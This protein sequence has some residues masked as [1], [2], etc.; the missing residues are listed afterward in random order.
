MWVTKI[1]AKAA[2]EA[3]R[4]RI[5]EDARQKG[6]SPEAI[7]SMAEELDSPCTEEMAAFDK[8]IYYA[9]QD[10]WDVIVFDTAPTGH[11]LRLLELPV[12]WSKQL[13]V[14]IYVSVEST[15]ADDVAKRRFGKVIDMMRD[16]DRCTFAFVMYPE[17]TPIVESY[18][19]M[20]ELR[21]VG[22]EP[23]L[24]V[25]NQVLPDEVCTTSYARSR[26]RMQRKY[27][28]EMQRRFQV[29]ILVVPLLPQ[30]ISG[31][32]TLIGLGDRLFKGA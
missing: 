21:T 32:D 10:D 19:A 16:P 11:T 5:L 23:G 25:A 24:V 6:R 30:E 15:A 26:Q 13:D 9:S 18:R 17:S 12:D 7:A 2:A 31:R 29:P 27:L 4:A 3:Y 20:E 22:I 14:K 8:F 1:D 28:A